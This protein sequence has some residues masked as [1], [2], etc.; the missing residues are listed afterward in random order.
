MAENGNKGKRK[1][2]LSSWKLDEKPAKPILPGHHSRGWHHRH[3]E[4]IPAKKATIM[5]APSTRPQW[6]QS[7]LLWGLLSLA[8]AIVLTVVAAM[9]HDIRWLLWFAWPLASWAIWEFLSYFNIRLKARL[10]IVS[11]GVVIFAIGIYGLYGWLSPEHENRVQAVPVPAVSTQPVLKPIVAPTKTP[12]FDEKMA[13]VNGIAEHYA[14]EHRGKSP[15]LDQVNQQLKQQG[16][17]F[18]IVHKPST[19][20]NFTLSGGSISGNGIGIRNNYPNANFVLQGVTMDNNKTAIDN[21]NGKTK[22]PK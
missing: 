3:P 9:R 16:E 17:A 7:T 12:T 10:I 14:K 20:P 4:S 19:H 2:D 18:R 15:T 5:D 11:G 22:Q 21:T 13:I 6:Y 1:P 8:G